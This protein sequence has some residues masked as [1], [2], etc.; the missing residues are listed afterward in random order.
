MTVGVVCLLCCAVCLLIQRQSLRII[1]E[2]AVQKAQSVRDEAN[3]EKLDVTCKVFRSAYTCAKEQLA[4][5]KHPAIME[6]QELNGQIKA[7]MLYS[8]HSCANILK[9]IAQKMK[10]ELCNYIKQSTHPFSIM[11]DET[12]TFFT[13]SA[14]IIFIRI[15]VGGSVCNFFCDLVEL[16]DGSVLRLLKQY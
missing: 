14:L 15:Q 9:H 16:S 7:A 1:T 13:K 11:I 4:C 2:G 5:T 12:T 3:A 8:H 6:L 10:A